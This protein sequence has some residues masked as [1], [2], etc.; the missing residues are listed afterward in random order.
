MKKI[1][2]IGAGGHAKVIADIIAKRK[3]ILNEDIEIIGY[4]DD[5]YNTESEPE[6]KDFPLL[7]KLNKI[8]ELDKNKTYFVIGIGDNNIRE[9]ISNKYE[10]NF[11]TAIHPNATIATNVQIG[12]GSVVM[13]NAVIN[14]KS[15][16]GNHCIINTGSIIEHDNRIMDFVHIS[17][18][19]TLAGGVEIGEKSWIGMGSNII[20]EITIGK[21]TIVGAGSLVLNDIADNTKVFGVPCKK[22]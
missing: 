21:D 9:N 13:A 8:E 1:I 17:P 2:I 5:K 20:Q 6:T 18:N 22:E 16:I 10:V 12:T 19:V 11:Y 14:T 7:G 15:I 3:N 4:L